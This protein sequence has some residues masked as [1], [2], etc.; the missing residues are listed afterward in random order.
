MNTTLQY[1]PPSKNT[2][3]VS[4]TFKDGSEAIIRDDPE[5]SMC[6]VGGGVATKLLR[7]RNSSCLAL[8]ELIR[9]EGFENCTITTETYG[10]T[11][12]SHG[13]ELENGILIFTGIRHKPWMVKKFSPNVPT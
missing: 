11:K 9:E 4:C 5:G 12:M 7:R 6:I 10:E 1:P 3:I 8:L 2:D 13:Q